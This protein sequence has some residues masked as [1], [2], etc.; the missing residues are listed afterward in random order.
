MRQPLKIPPGLDSDD[1]TYAAKG[2]WADASCVRFWEDYPQTIGGWESVIP[3]ALGGVCRTAFAWTDNAASLNLGF[4]THATL[5]LWQGGALYGITPTLARPPVALGAAPFTVTDGSATVSV[6]QTN[7]GLETSDSVSFSGATAVGRLTISGAYT[8]TVVDADHYTIT[9]GGAAD[10]VKTL[11]SNPLATVS[12]S[13][14]VTVTET[15]HNIADG[16]TVTIAGASAVGGITPNGSFAITVI[17]ANSYK[18]TFGSNAGSTATG[19]GSSVTAT[20]PT[21]GGGSSVIAAP[22]EAFTSGAINGTGGAGYGTGAYSTGTYSSPSTAE[23]Y[24]RTW[25]LAA[26]GQQLLACP[27]G[28]TIYAWANN[29]GVVAAPLT[30]APRQVTAMLVAPQDMVFALG[31][32]EEASDTFNPL[33]IRHSG[34]RVNTEWNTATDT[35]AREYILPGGG[36]IVGGKVIGP[37]I[38]VWTSHSLFLGTYVGQ[39]GQVW[40]FDRIGDKC[41]LIGPNAAVVV[42]S[43]AFWLGPDLQFYTY[44][45]G[46]S[47]QPLPCPIRKDMAANFAPSQGDKVVASSISE[48]SEIRW[49]YPDSRDGNE[50]SRYL[51]LSLQGQGWSRGVMARTA[52]LDAGPSPSPIGVTYSGMI[53]WHERGQTADGSALAWYVESADQMLGDNV[54]MMVRQIWPDFKNQKGPVSV[55]L[56]SRLKQ[57]GQETVNGPTAMAAGEEKVDLRATGRYFR[58]KFAGNS[59]PSDARIGVPV[60]DIVPLGAR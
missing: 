48:F 15:G 1:T 3:T 30:N 58:V 57:Q 35:T 38:L 54:T 5:E 39:L 55:T 22:Q 6:A 37:Y 32:N 7:H 18:F 60:F 29:T 50:N 49:D 40:R 53:Y 43:Q 8:V 45:L 24:P 9:A 13:P 28:G 4:G 46:G 17:D 42:G 59:S 12:G 36:F 21:T 2:R 16:T 23:Y 26:W 31:C 27:R 11:G 14:I 33:C 47:V 19:G 25:S 51:S 20:V 34:V 10:T 52:F 56:T 41:G 44:A